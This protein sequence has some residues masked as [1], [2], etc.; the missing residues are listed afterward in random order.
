MRDKELLNTAVNCTIVGSIISLSSI[1][2]MCTGNILVEQAVITIDAQMLSLFN[3]LTAGGI[4]AG[5]FCIGVPF[6]IVCA[7]NLQ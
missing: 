6:G 4:F 3:W 5:C 7:R 1:I 2:T